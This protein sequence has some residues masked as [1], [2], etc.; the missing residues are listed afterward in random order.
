M[1]AKAPA[2]EASDL[3]G[4]VEKLQE[5]G[6][7]IRSMGP[8]VVIMGNGSRGSL[9]GC[10]AFLERQGVRWF[11]PGK[12][13]EVVP[14]HAVNW[15]T[16]L[17]ISESPTFPKRILFYWPNNYSSVVDWIDFSA[18]LRLNRVAFHYTWPAR[19]W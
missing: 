10:Y 7:I 1:P 4:A 2:A 17:N 9:Y 19:D 13:Y 14:H 18:K 15:T 8:D 6:F 12:Q 16:P 11:F 3:R 5:D